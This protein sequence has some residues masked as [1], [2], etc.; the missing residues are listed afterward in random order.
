MLLRYMNTGSNHVALELSRTKVRM[1]RNTNS[2][3]F[4]R[5]RTMHMVLIDSRRAISY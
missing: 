1:Y 2:G 4:C 5:Q 3:T